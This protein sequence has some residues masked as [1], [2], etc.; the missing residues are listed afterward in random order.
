MI[1]KKVVNNIY[2]HIS[3][4]SAQTDEIQEAIAKAEQLA[5]V[6]ANIDY[7]VVK[8]DI[9]GQGLSL[10]YYQ[11][12]FDAPFPFLEKSY[13]VDLVKQRTEKRSYEASLNPPILHRKE[14]LL[15]EHHPRI[16]EYRELTA[17]AW[18][19]RQSDLDWL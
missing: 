19:V 11:D 9:N 17:T 1:G 6:Q 14:L 7:N 16:R 2:W 12:F 4:T 18:P 8:Y 15:S 3:L 10:L 13:R 5:D